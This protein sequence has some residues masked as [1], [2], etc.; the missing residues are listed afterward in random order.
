MQRGKLFAPTANMSE[1][2]LPYPILPGPCPS[3]SANLV[4][5]PT[6]L[7]LGCGI[8]L[9]CVS[10]GIAPLFSEDAP[11]EP[12]VVADTPLEWPGGFSLEAK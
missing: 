7:V 9:L 1:T 2:R 6:V 12:C 10:S 5:F 11:E 8:L 3:S 4:F